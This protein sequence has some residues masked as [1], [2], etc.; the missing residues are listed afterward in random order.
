M[1]EEDSSTFIQYLRSYAWFDEERLTALKE[2]YIIS[3]TKHGEAIFWHANVNRK[4]TNGHILTM[5]AHNGKVYEA[6]WYFHDNQPTN[7]A[8]A[9]NSTSDSQ[10]GGRR[11]QPI[12]LFGE[13]LLNDSPNMPVALVKSE[14]SACVMSCFPTPYLWLATGGT[15]VTSDSLAVLK[16]RTVIVFPNKGD[17]EKWQ[18]LAADMPDVTIYVSDVMERYEGDYRTI[19]SAMLSQQPLRPTPEQL[20]LE[21]MKKSNPAFAKLVDTLA[22]E[23]VSVE[24]GKGVCSK[25]GSPPL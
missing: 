16:G 15:K 1:K 14:T 13:H 5:D 18:Q 3:A 24:Y 21:E 6:S 23:V 11:S 25:D 20:A 17:Y 7:E 8:R 22:L 2:L 12:C 9:E 19:A 4:V 10:G